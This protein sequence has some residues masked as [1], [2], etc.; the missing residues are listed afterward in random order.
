LSHSSTRDARGD[1]PENVA[2]DGV[3][4]EGH[5]IARLVE[6][7]QTGKA[8]VQR[9]AEQIAGVFVPVVIRLAVA[10]LGFWLANGAG[11]TFAFIAAVAVL[12]IA[13]PCALGRATLSWNAI[14]CLAAVVVVTGAI[15]LLKAHVPVLSPGVLDIVAVLPIAI[16]WGL[17]YAVAV[18]IAGMGAFNFLFLP[19]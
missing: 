12:I 14:K 16:F 1:E 19:F 18:S 11:A 13:C 10:T 3:V 5:Q 15:E 7:A 2:T 6:E 8:P 4:E 9:L 17:G